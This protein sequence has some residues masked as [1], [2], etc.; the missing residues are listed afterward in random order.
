MADIINETGRTAT[1]AVEKIGIASVVSLILMGF[2]VWK[3]KG[4]S[5]RDERYETRQQTQ[6]DRLIGILE[7]N[8]KALYGVEKATDNS[9]RAIEF[10]TAESI[11]TRQVLEKH[12]QTLTK[13]IEK[14]E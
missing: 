1:T 6:E 11:K 10:N 2:I 7:N 13:L 3:E 8:S 4:V 14:M 12:D 9:S 5:E